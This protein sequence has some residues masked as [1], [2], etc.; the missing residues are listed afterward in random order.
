MLSVSEANERLRVETD[1]LHNRH[2]SWNASNLGSM[3][4]SMN[5]LEYVGTEFIFVRNGLAFA[6]TRFA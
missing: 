4:R 2:M 5:G 6:F 1:M 3:G